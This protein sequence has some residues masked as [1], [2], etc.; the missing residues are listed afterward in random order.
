MNYRQWFHTFSNRIAPLSTSQPW[1]SSEHGDPV[2]SWR[3]LLNRNS[4]ILE[5]EDEVA[6]EQQGRL[7]MVSRNRTLSSLL[8]AALRQQVPLPITAQLLREG[9]FTLL[10]LDVATEPTAEPP[11]P[12]TVLSWEDGTWP[13]DS[14]TWAVDP[15]DLCLDGT[16]DAEL[17]LYLVGADEGWQASDARWCA[18]LRALGIPILPVLVITTPGAQTPD[19]FEHHEETGVQGTMMAQIQRNVGVRPVTICLA[20]P[21]EPAV[22]PVVDGAELHLL[23]KRILA[24]RPRLAIPLA[25]ESPPCRSLIAR[26]IIRSGALVAALVGSEPL[27]LLD[28]PLQVA[29]HWKVILQL[30]AIYGRPGLDYRSR[31]MLGTVG[32][33]LGVRF[34]AQQAIKLIPF[35]GWLASGL[36]SG[37]S[38]ALL[39]HTVLHSYEQDK[40]LQLAQLTRNWRH[41]ATRVA[42]HS[43]RVVAGHV[44][45]LPVRRGQRCQP[46][47]EPGSFS[48]PVEEYDHAQTIPITCESTNN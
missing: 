26:R 16:A 44:G 35:F 41:I 20:H 40:P 2:P 37:C 28:I 43:A 46:P 27:P 1:A 13:N 31:E 42:E 30:A 24:L 15:W 4:A 6:T 5:V 18:R 22:A 12:P 34:L 25:Q 9:F 3:T 38:M 32:L 45:R 14:P 8:L 19:Q 11:D 33:N 23:V 39:G 47:T 21:N 7:V 36:L 17:L 29:V 48:N 10:T